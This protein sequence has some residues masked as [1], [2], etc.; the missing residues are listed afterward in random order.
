MIKMRD[1][2]QWVEVT[3]VKDLFSFLQSVSVVIRKMVFIR[4]RLIDI[5]LSIHASSRLTSGTLG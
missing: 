3:E 4:G 5:R 2:S 1:S